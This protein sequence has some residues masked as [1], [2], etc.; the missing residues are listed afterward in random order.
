MRFKRFY[1]SIPY[2]CLNRRG[3]YYRYSRYL[4][5]NGGREKIKVC[6]KD[7]YF[8]ETNEVIEENKDGKIEIRAVAYCRGD[9]DES[10]EKIIGVIIW[11]DGETMEVYQGRRNKNPDTFGTV[12]H[13]K[14]Y[15]RGQV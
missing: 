14:V 7:F 12:N 5:E 2:T 1:P 6:T 9:L 13:T 15:L 4:N 8:K 3:T 10:N 11:D